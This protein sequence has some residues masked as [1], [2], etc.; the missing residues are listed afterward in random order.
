M[1]TS[2]EKVKLILGVSGEAQDTLIDAL[3]PF[4]EADYL[5]IRNK[6][7]DTDDDDNIVYPAN[8]EMTAI[9]MVGYHLTQKGLGGIIQSKSM[10]VLSLTYKTDEQIDGYPAPVVKQIKRYQEVG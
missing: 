4:V 1:I 8:A 7:F 5:D 10:G 2:T 6:A 3:I 9:R